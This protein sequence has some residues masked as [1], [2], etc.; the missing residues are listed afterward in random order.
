MKQYHD[1]PH[2]DFAAVQLMCAQL[3]LQQN[4]FKYDICAFEESQKMVYV[5]H[6]KGKQPIFYPAS[7][8]LRVNTDW[9]LHC[10]NFFRHHIVGQEWGSLKNSLEE[11]DVEELP[12]A[13]RA[14]LQRAPYPLSRNWKGTYA[15]LNDVELEHIRTQGNAEEHFIDKNLDDEQSANIQASRITA[16]CGWI[17]FLF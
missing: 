5:H 3:L 2:P 9:T 11:L 8:G 17:L 13:W 1:K 16:A 4:V 6:T 15:Y 14:P 10:V 7:Y 12:S